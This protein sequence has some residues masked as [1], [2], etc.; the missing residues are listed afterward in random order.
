MV[1]GH[2]LHGGCLLRDDN[3]VA[4]LRPDA[5]SHRQIA[6]SVRLDERVH[7]FPDWRSEGH[8]VR[9]SRLKF[10]APTRNISFFS[11]WHA[12][13]CSRLLPR[14]L[15]LLVSGV[16][17]DSNRMAVATAIASRSNG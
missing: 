8:S 9:I 16:V 3:L 7:C 1:A 13:Y 4:C 14:L 11:I 2:R 6:R 5:L 10:C 12:A 15:S 17:V